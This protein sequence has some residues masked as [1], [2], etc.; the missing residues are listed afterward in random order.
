MEASADGG[1][2][3]TGIAGVGMGGGRGGEAIRSLKKFS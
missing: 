2:G 1:V 3:G